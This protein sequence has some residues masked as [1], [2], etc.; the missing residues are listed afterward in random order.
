MQ[1]QTFWIL[2]ASLLL[3]AC[4]GGDS[5]PSAKRNQIITAVISA[6]IVVK[7][8]EE[9][10]L[11]AADSNSDADSPLS[12]QWSIVQEPGL[13]AA[14]VTSAS[15]ATTTL[16]PSMEGIYR[17]R[18]K[19][20]N[21]TVSDIDEYEIFAEYDE[22]EG[23]D[24]DIFPPDQDEWNDPDV[25]YSGECNYANEYADIA[26]DLNEQTPPFQE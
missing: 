20:S 4:G 7:V 9:V 17:L 13:G 6:P 24:K 3:C 1:K 8:N 18:L 16:I 21:G 22:G 19:V 23:G 2:L 11:S 25:G 5:N 10:T 12:F 26:V 14:E 15:A